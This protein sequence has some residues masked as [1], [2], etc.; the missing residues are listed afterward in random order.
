[1]FLNLLNSGVNINFNIL[2]QKIP[3]IKVRN[4]SRNI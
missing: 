4:D 2:F 1:M 3:N